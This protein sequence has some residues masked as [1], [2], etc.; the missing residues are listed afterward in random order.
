MKKPV[1]FHI[2]NRPDLTKRV[3]DQICIY[4]PE[5]LFVVADGPRANHPEDAQNCKAT[6]AII[7]HVDWKCEV[8]KNYS[9]LNMGSYNRNFSG[10]SWLFDN[11]DEAIILEDDC[12]PHSTFFLYCEELLSRY[13]DDT[14]ISVISGDNF[15][16]RTPDARYS[17][18]FSRNVLTWGWASWRRTWK[19]IDPEMKS[20]PEFRKTGF[21]NALQD[22]RMRSY[23]DRIFQAIY[24]GKRKPAW[25]YQ[26][27][28]TCYMQNMLSIIP[29]VNLVSNI[30]F[31]SL[32]TN[33]VNPNAPGANLST[34]PIRL[35]LNHPPYVTPDFDADRQLHINLYDIPFAIR[36]YRRILWKIRSSRYT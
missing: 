26:L 36:V 27:M 29:N 8:K 13:R 12:L 9:D 19:L 33:C 10:L 18:S 20:W 15:L 23:W 35:P 4:K 30:G 32:G 16:S 25:D 1:S 31:G 14:R 34:Y 11:V 7:D 22:Y 24:E 2:F 5:Q 6:R 21:H 28:L 17:Y 3:F